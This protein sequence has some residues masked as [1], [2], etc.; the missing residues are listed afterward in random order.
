MM[1]NAEC[2]HG[3]RVAVTDLSP[4]SCQW[5][6]SPLT[7]R[8]PNGHAVPLGH[9]SCP[10]CSVHLDA[11]ATPRGF[12]TQSGSRDMPAQRSNASAPPRSGSMPGGREPGGTMTWAPPS[13]YPVGQLPSYAQHPPTPSSPTRGRNTTILVVACLL[14]AA[15]G[16]VGIGVALRNTSA[17]GPTPEHPISGKAIVLPVTL[18]LA[19]APGSQFLITAN[20]AQTVATVMWHLWENALVHGDTRALTQLVSNPLRT[21]EVYQCACALPRPVSPYAILTEV[22]LKQAYPLYFL[23]E[24]I[25]QYKVASQTSPQY[26][27]ELQIITKARPSAPWQLSLATGYNEVDGSQP[28]PVGMNAVPVAPVPPSPISYSYNPPPNTTSIVPASQYLPTLAAYWQ[29]WKT[30][31][32]A[33]RTQSSSM[34]AA[35]LDSVPRLLSRPKI[36]T[37]STTSTSIRMIL[38]GSSRALKVS[39]WYAAPSSTPRR[40]WRI[41][42]R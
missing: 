7:V 30:T 21:S 31:G 25:T 36:S 33:P 32:R 34:M 15:V 41:L 40:T 17:T 14:I 9:S 28:P 6:G 35:P 22:P 20:D 12:S 5:C 29:S 42:A 13:G 8:C 2:E 37:T 38:S 16:A 4:R 18:Y 10:K 19:H 27:M 24:I 3:H 11:S 39:R 1:F 26:G 23:S